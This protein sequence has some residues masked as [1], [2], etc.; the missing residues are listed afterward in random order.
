MPKVL[1]DSKGGLGTT[2]D[3]ILTLVQFQALHGA[4]WVLSD[5][6]N[7]VG[8]ALHAL[9]GQTTVADFRG[10]F[11]RGLDNGR[12]VDA[13]RTMSSA[14]GNATAKNEPKMKANNLDILSNTKNRKCRWYCHSYSV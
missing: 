5:G 13:A 1:D 2:V 4:G 3:S 6:Q 12:G 7:I 10:E 9:T 14:Q 8:S 11:K